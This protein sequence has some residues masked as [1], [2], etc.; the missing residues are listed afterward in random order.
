MDKKN[1]YRRPVLS[2]PERFFAK[3]VRNW[4]MHPE[5]DPELTEEIKSGKHPGLEILV[6][7]VDR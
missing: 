7:E 3:R 6:E 1:A 4:V 5:N 2:E